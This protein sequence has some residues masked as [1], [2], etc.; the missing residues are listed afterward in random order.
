MLVFMERGYSR[1]MVRRLNRVRIHMQVLFLLDVLTVSGN[2]IDGA[3]LSLWPST[4]KMSTLNWPKEEQTTADMI[5]WKEA[6]KDICPSRRRLNCLGQ[7]V[8]KSH[9][10]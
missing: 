5:L 8:T 6:L 3:A 1:E 4:K 7:Y 10:V 9:W 2:R